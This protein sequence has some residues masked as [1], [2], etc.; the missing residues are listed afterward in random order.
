MYKIKPIMETLDLVVTG[1][2]WGTGKRTGWMSS[3]MLATK[4]SKS[5]QFL[6]IGR[7][8]T[9]VTDQ[10]LEEFTLKLKPLIVGE[11]GI[12]VKIKPEFVVEVAFQEIQKSTKYNS[13]YALRFPR[14]VRA[15]YD[16]SQLDADD[17]A[18]VSSL[19]K[20]QKMDS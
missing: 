4:D 12:I 19:Y 18:K 2:K 6:S 3:Y 13:G 7:V 15:R 20:L 8:G 9:G 11:E 14:V 1:A 5:G 17:M 16:K 10:Q